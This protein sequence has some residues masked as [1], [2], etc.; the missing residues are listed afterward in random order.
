MLTVNEILEGT[1]FGRTQSVGQMEVV[2]ILDGGS[3]SDNTFAPPHF[4]AG[5]QDYSRVEVRNLDADRPSITPTGAGWITRQAAQDHATAG[6]VLLKPGESRVIENA[7][8]IQET[9]G[10][11][12]KPNE[13]TM[14]VVLPAALRAQALAMRTGGDLGRLWPSI[15]SASSDLGVRGAGNLVEM[16]DRY[17]QEL[18]EF[19]A[20]FELMPN[21][22]GAVVLI[23]GQVV[24]VERAPSVPFWTRL[25]V[26]LVRVCYGTL[27]LKARRVLGDVRPPTRPALNVQEQSLVGIK[28]A[29][30]VARVSAQGLIETAVSDVRDTPLLVS[31]QG[32]ES[33]WGEYEVLTL[34][35]TRLAGQIVQNGGKTPYV[36]LCAAGA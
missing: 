29:L 18:D 3:A 8:C 25:W 10:G 36:S 7:V 22:I 4:A 13:D 28:A 23:N 27:A 12:W 19:V 16:L 17:S 31:G 24:G 2:P 6:A 33:R 35:N 20:E 21:Q 15:R 5:T 14:L 9:Q 34:A 32:A 1:R 11:V 26:P 30:D